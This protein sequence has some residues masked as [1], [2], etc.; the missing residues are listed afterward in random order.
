MK[1]RQRISKLDHFRKN[2]KEVSKGNVL[3]CTDVGSRG[4]DIPEVDI[5][6]NYHIPLNTENMVHRSGRTARANKEGICYNLV[7]EKEL[8]LYKSI[9]RE[10]KIMKLLLKVCIFLIWISTDQYLS[11]LKV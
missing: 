5:V 7:S 11:M 10:L 9:L 2:A 1:Q 6:I 4:L 3:I 8:N